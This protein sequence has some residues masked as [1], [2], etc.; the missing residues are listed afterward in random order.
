MDQRRPADVVL[1]SS[2]ARGRRA[3]RSGAQNEPGMNSRP[4]ESGFQPRGEVFQVREEVS[5]PSPCPGEGRSSLPA[6]PGRSAHGQV[7]QVG[8]VGVVGEVGGVVGSEGV[9]GCVGA[10]VLGSGSGSG[11]ALGVV[12]AAGGAVCWTI[13]ALM[14]GMLKSIPVGVVPLP[15]VDPPP[16]PASAMIAIKDASA[17]SLCA[18][19]LISLPS[20]LE[21][22]A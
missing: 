2:I 18:S 14:L 10:G 5:R 15:V 9:E 17:I 22:R 3:L 7:G 21:R 4:K 1:D 6:R 8:D 19:L 13:G 16:Q 12:G 11:S 20:S